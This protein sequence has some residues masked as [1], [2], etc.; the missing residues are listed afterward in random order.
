MKPCEL[1]EPEEVSWVV[2]VLDLDE[3]SVVL[4]KAER[5][6]NRVI[7]LPQPYAFLV[8]DEEFDATSNV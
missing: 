1:V 5:Q 7:A 8:T 3:A 6:T 4:A 2:P